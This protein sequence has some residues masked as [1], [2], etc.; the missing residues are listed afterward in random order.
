MSRLINHYQYQQL[1]HFRRGIARAVVT[2]DT[3]TMNRTI[4][5]VQG[6]LI[7]LVD[8]GEID[9][10]DMTALEAETFAGVDF[11]LNARKAANASQH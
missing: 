7:G 6:Y 11:L 3:A 2:G 9:H 10:G 5:M 8:A 4:G 1:T